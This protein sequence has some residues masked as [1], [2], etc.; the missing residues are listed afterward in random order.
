MLSMG[1]IQLLLLMAIRM[2]VSST[3]LLWQ[4]MMV[5]LLMSLAMVVQAGRGSLI[6]MP[7]ST[8]RVLHLFLRPLRWRGE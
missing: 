4:P 8:R 5:L 2:S 3:L 6:W 7:L 1:T